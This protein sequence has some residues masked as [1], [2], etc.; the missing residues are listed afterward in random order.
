[1]HIGKNH[2]EYKCHSIFVDKWEEKEDKVDNGKE[3]IEDICVGKVE[4]ENSEEEKYLG[5]VVTKDGKNLKNIQARVNKGRG[6]VKR[7]LDILEGIPFGKLYFQVA[8]I[9]R[10]SLLVSSMLCNSETWFNLTKAE[11]ELLETV[12]VILLRTILGASKGVPKEMIY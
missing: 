4:M 8:I 5:D 6:I 11:L 1:M 2:E 3:I 9:L 12:D 7:I 10:N